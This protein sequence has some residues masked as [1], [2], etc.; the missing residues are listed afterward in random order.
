MD[1]GIPFCHEG[2]PLGQPHPRVERPG[3]PRRLVRRPSSGCTPPTTSPSSPA[4]SA[5]PP[6][7][8][9]ACSASTPTRSPSSGSST[10]SSSGPGPRAGS[11]PVPARAPHRQAGGGGR[12]GPGRP[13][14]RPAAGPGRPR[15]RRLRAGRAPRRPAPLRHPRVQDGEGRP[16]PPPGPDEAEGVEFRCGVSVGAAVARRAPGRWPTGADRRRRRPTWW[17]GT[18]PWSWPAGPPCPGTCA[19]PGRALDGIHLAM[20]YLKPSNL[21]QEGSLAATP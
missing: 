17:P 20:E 18:T 7:R 9:A 8:A 12:L 19:V 11:A 6:A 10:R 21:V 15:R 13:G 2:C 5:R 14:R 4:G 3:L 16:R 1:C